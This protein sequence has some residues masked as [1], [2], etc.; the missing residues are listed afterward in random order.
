MKRNAVAWAA[1]VLSVAAFVSSRSFT[2]AVPAAQQI[3]DEGQKT[4]KALSD[5]FGAV[6]EFV[7]PSVV[8]INVEKKSGPRLFGGG[9]GGQRP[10]P[11]NPG[12]PS[13]D[14]MEEFLR[15]FFGGRNFGGQDFKFEKEQF[16]QAGTGSGFVYDTKGHILTNNHVVEGADRIM[17]SFHDGVDLPAKVVGRHPE[18]DVAVIHVESSQYRPLPLGRSEKLKVGEWVLAVGSPFGLD[19]TVTAGIISATERDD[20]GINSYESFVQTDAAVNPGNSGG[21]LVDLN[22]RV[23]GINSAIATASRS[24]SGVGFAIPI[25]M[26]V[27]LADKL[28]KTGKVSPARMGVAIEPV[29]PKLARS[30]GLDPKTKG[31]LIDQVGKGTPADKAGL[32]DGDIIT[33]FD[34]AAVNSRKSLQYLVSTSDIGKSYTLTFLREGQEHQTKVTP[35]AANDVASAF[36]GPASSP[37]RSPAP[38]KSEFNEF[39]IAVQAVTPELAKKYEYEE[40]A[41]GLVITAVKEDSSAANAGL[42][43]GDRIT[44]I[45]KDRKPQ[46]INDVKAFED[47]AKHSDEISIFVEDVN[48]KLP[49]EF[50]TLSRTEK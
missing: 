2:R 15:R 43:P 39:G 45:I 22:G 37:S 50:K 5:A 40:G 49:S 28:I 30:L 24:N 25:D 33:R 1:L 12:T 35:E 13:P 42:E 17:V 9:R 16:V 11:N 21:P 32:M 7:K 36:Q 20:V 10:N 14:D 27:R 41:N 48:K 34:G 3:P 26:A 8:Q 44:K 18:T 46:T 38:A 31:L 29:T 6:S 47:Y 4:A 23:I 19:Q